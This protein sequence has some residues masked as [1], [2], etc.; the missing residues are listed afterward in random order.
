M[1]K[2]TVCKT[3]RVDKK[4][5]CLPKQA[6]KMYKK[7]LSLLENPKYPSLNTHRYD[8]DRGKDVWGSYAS[9]RD[10]VFWIYDSDW[11]IFVIDIDSH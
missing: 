10:R 11:T 6:Q 5:S 4:I 3:A 7:A 8:E 9:K 2:Y 1:E